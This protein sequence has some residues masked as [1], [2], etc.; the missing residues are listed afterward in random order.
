MTPSSVADLGVVTH[1][2]QAR[3]ALYS[4]QRAKGGEREGVRKQLLSKKVFL[5]SKKVLE[6]KTPS[7]KRPETF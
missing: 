2:K 6:G 7:K 1:A 3:N 4:S 5:C